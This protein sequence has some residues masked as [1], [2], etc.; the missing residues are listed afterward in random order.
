MLKQAATG[1]VRKNEIKKT[2]GYLV[3]AMCFYPRGLRRE[4][5]DEYRGDLAP[6]RALLKDF[7]A[8]VE[9]VGHNAAFAEVRYEERFQLSAAALAHLRHLSALSQKQDVYLICQCELGQRCHREILMLLAEQKFSAPIEKTYFD[10][11]IALR[12]FL[13][14]C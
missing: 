5:R 3:I 14:A 13:E 8:A 10:Y 9:K 12:R 11:P 6:D 1:Q 4:L 2:D 7:K